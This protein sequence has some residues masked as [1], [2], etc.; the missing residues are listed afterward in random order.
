MASYFDE[1]AKNRYKSLLLFFFLALF[2]VGIVFLFSLIFGGGLLGLIFSIIIVAI[3]SIIVLSTGDKL[4]LKVSKAKPADKV[5]QT[6]LYNIVEGLSAAAQIPMPSLY[7]IDDPNPNAFATGK[8]KKKASIAVTTGLLSTMNRE[9]LEG[10]LAHETSHIA[11]NDIQYMMI[12]VVFAG[13]IGIL[14]AFARNML[15]FGGIRINERGQAGIIMI[16][17]FIVLA[18]IAPLVALLVKLAISRRREY[19]ADANGARLTRNPAGL[20]SALMKIKKYEENPKSMPLKT[21]TEATAP[22]YISN[23]FKKGSFSNLFSTHPPIEERIK[24]LQA[25]Y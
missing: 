11:N 17:I 10:V 14:A 1:I 24:R 7:V 25:M 15:F 8:S 13:A 18:I 9:E 3:Y 22:L 4:V 20:A 6:S 16:A 19:M 21:A 2:F 23:P 5:S 12:A